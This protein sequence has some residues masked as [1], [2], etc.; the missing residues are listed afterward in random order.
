MLGLALPGVAQPLTI[1]F[2]SGPIPP[3]D[4]STFTA[5]VAGI[6]TLYPWGSSPW[7]VYSIYSLG[8]NITTDHPE[9]LQITLTSPEG[10]T[11]LLS[12]FN[13]AGGQNYTGT[14]FIAGGSDITTGS[15]PFTGWWAPQGGDFSVF[16]GEDADGTWVITVI[17]TACAGGPN[18]G[19]GGAQNGEGWN[20]GWFDGNANSGGFTMAFNTPPPPCMIDMGWQQATICPGQTVDVLSSFESAWGGSGVTLIVSSWTGSV[21]DPYAVA[22]AGTYYIEGY[23]WWGECYY[24][25]SYEVYAAPSI[26]LGGDQAVTQCSGAGPVDLTT[27]FN[28]AGATTAT[29][30][31]DG[32]PISSIEAA[33][34]SSPGVYEVAATNFGCSD[35]A[36][37][38]L[39][40]ADTPVLGPDQT[41]TICA[42]GSADLATLFT[43]A[44]LSATWSFNSAPISAPTAASLPGTYTVNAVTPDGCIDEAVATLTV[45][46]PPALGPDQAAS[47]CNNTSLDLT[48]F[49]TTDGMSAAWTFIGAPVANP[50]AVQQAGTYQLVAT[51]AAG[52]GDTAL[53][54]V[55]VLLSPLLG[56][57]LIDS[58]CE[59]EPLDLTGFYPTA[60]LTTSWTFGGLPVPDPTAVMTPGVYTLVAVDAN[61]CTDTAQ[62]TV[63]LMPL[64]VLGPDQSLTGCD[65]VAVDLTG[66][67]ATGTDNTAWTLAGAPVADPTAVTEAGTYTLTVTNAAGCTAT[68][69]VTLQLDPSPALGGD[70]STSTCA[71]TSTDLTAFFSTTGLST[72]WTW[73]G[74]PVADPSAV[75]ASG[76]Y[77]LVVTN[78]FNCTD[79]AVVNYT[80]HANPEL[81]GDL[82][83]ALCPWQTV[84]LSAVFPTVGMTAAYM[85]NGAEVGDA[86][87]VADSGDYVVR[88]TDANGC[89]DEATARVTNVECLCTADFTADARCIQEPARFT[90]VA[91][92]AIVG[93][94]WEFGAAAGSATGI[95]PEVM[96]AVEGEL[97]VTMTAQ[98]SCGTVTVERTITLQDCADSCAV[99]IPNAFTPNSDE[100][101]DAW[102]WVG[103]CDPE[104]FLLMVFNRWGEL[105][106]STEDPLAKWDGTYQGTV[107][108]DGVYV[109]RVRYR[110]PYQARK[111]LI[112]HVTLLR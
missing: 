97:L 21:P 35:T 95:N 54:V 26:A 68:A 4:T 104:E 76:S 25:G 12:A 87:A 108:Q 56:M 102:S 99:Y 57:D 75:S 63:E 13:G 96:L 38:T 83:F 49:F 107:S 80:V 106:Y 22:V 71:G 50:T 28:F 24:Y 66:L 27:L 64:P 15:A 73:G 72:E 41:A 86:T 77:Q 92:S 17:D 94:Q 90:A 58:T 53:V 110:L 79:T 2:T 33:A 6:G 43:L 7:G 105:I 10:T 47:I 52:C 5:N 37:V 85:L 29:W 89:T 109:Y 93:A 30:T 23:D 14:N 60:G 88:I 78:G 19:P 8:V 9:Y 100:R 91:D 84:D 70:Q 62:T 44:G 45:E 69:M 74:T 111:D 34:A 65:A 16:D 20:P 101:N 40:V 1:P 42:G 55:S 98:L 3:C 82:S 81:G 18:A 59:D 32:A 51:T 11:L 39:S 112:G 103:D 46:N 61:N 48:A 36:Q 31:H 67:Y